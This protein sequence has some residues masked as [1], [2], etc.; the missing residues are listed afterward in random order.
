LIERIQAMSN[1]RIRIQFPALALWLLE[2][3]GW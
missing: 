3:I 1:G 2:A